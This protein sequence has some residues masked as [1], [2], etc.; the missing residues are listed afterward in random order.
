MRSYYA[1][2]ETAMGKGKKDFSNKPIFRSSAIF[3]VIKRDGITSRILFMGYWLIKRQIKQIAAV[4]TLRSLDGI[5]LNRN[6]FHIEEAK[7]FRIELEDQLQE[8]GLSEKD[9]FTGSL[10][11]EF[12]STVNMVFPFPAAVINYYGPHFCTQVHTAQRVYN[13]YD[14][15]RTN[16]QKEV[17]E[18]GFNVYTDVVK[19]PFIS[20]INGSDAIVDNKINMTFFNSDNEV[21]KHELKLGNM[22]PYQMYLLYPA[23]F[24]DLKEFLKG[25]VGSAKLQFRVNGIF[26]RLIVGNLDNSLP[27][28]S[29]T[30][31]YYDCTEA[32]SETDYWI[33]VDPNWHPAAMIAPI[34]SGPD[35]F[36]NIYFYPIYSPSNFAID[37]EIFNA[38]GTLLGK[39]ENALTITAPFKDFAKLSINEMLAEHGISKSD[40]LMARVSA[41]P[42]NNSR[43]PAR[44]KIGLDIGLV[45]GKMPCNI[46]TNLQPYL[47]QLETKPSTFHWA[48][49]IADQPGACIWII[50]TSLER[51]YQKTAEIKLTFYHEKDAQIITR[52]L[53]L[54]PLGFTVIEVDKDNELKQ[55]FEGKPGWCTIVTTAPYTACYYLTKHPSGVIGGDH[56]F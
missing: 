27:A 37:I 35:E 21:L 49:M 39:Q 3:P 7:T 52:Q 16:S 55:F 50:N 43:L 23:R 30:H 45:K 10:E 44:V 22:D 28:V 40:N 13:D 25:K 11:I 34:Y 14:D 9:S 48:P 36:T 29:I 26:P 33:N 51:N 20:L 47:P 53:V 38:Q 56:C 12:F 15:M 8:A 1:H 41:R 42:A 4:V 46:C 5:V 17:P 2:L 24:L 54:P 18:A 31:T 19:E 32:T 6:H